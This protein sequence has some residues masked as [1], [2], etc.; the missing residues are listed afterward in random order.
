MV[1]NVTH[2]F[3]S[4]SNFHERWIIKMKMILIT[5]VLFGIA[6][7]KCNISETYYQT[8]SAYIN[9]KSSSKFM[10][11][12]VTSSVCMCAFACFLTNQCEAFTFN[13]G[14]RTCSLYMNREVEFINETT[15]DTQLY[16]GDQMVMLFLMLYSYVLRYYRSPVE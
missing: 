16:V 2:R 13:S 3:S 11:S 7:V 8:S 15:T 4:I 14:D 6:M 12:H 1:Y 10:D 5:R 9:K